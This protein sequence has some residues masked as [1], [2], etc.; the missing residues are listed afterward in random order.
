VLV[1]GHGVASASAN[2]PIWQ[3]WLH[4]LVALTM[5]KAWVRVAKLTLC[6]CAN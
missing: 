3:Q 1:G 5:G 2:P 6:N 4:D